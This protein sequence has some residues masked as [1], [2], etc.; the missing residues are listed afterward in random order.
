VEGGDAAAVADLR[1]RQN[2]LRVVAVGIF[3]NFFLEF[4]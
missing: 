1:L 4:V 2:L 3:L